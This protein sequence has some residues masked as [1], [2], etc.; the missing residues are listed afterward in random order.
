VGRVAVPASWARTHPARVYQSTGRGEARLA[1]GSVLRQPLSDTDEATLTEPGTGRA[2]TGRTAV[3]Q[4]VAQIRAQERIDAQA[5]DRAHD[6]HDDGV[7]VVPPP[8]GADRGRPVRAGRGRDPDA[9][10]S[11]QHAAV[12]LIDGR[13]WIEDLGSTIAPGW[14]GCGG[15]DPGLAGTELMLAGRGLD[16]LLGA[17]GTGRGGLASPTGLAAELVAEVPG[18][19]RTAGPWRC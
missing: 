11:R 2:P 15:E 19:A 8:R 17:A 1:I 13:V 12:E 10:L 9:S 4:Q 5:Q 18:R 14:T 16:R 3:E 7:R 6:P